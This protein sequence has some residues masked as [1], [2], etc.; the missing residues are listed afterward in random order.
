MVPSTC[1]FYSPLP[2]ND[3]CKDGSGIVMEATMANASSTI[4]SVM[5][6]II[7]AF[8]VGHIGIGSYLKRNGKSTRFVQFA[9]SL[10]TLIAL[11]GG[12]LLY[13]R[14]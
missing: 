11:L 3:D 2:E 13:M 1:C 5:V 10:A 4:Y 12:V 14:G 6:I 8:A 9:S 7:L